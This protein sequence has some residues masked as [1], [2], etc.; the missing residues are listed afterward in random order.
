MSVDMAKKVGGSHKRSPLHVLRFLRQPLFAAIIISGVDAIIS[1]T[2]SGT[3]WKPTLELVLLL[4]GGLGLLAG[5]GIALSSTP[6]VSK[7]GETMLGTA[8]W[9]R[10][11]EKNSE[12][13]GLKWMLGSCVLIAAGFGLS[14]L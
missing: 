13:A 2:F 10:E 8:S 14:V 1:F 11:A 12:R 3:A 4:Q 7:V 5:T 6:S 9:S